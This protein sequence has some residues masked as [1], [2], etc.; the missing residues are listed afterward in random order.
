MAPRPP[1]K[2][3]AVSE[4]LEK[5]LPEQAEEEGGGIDT[6]P[7]EKNFWSIAKTFLGVGKTKKPIR[8]RIWELD[9]LKTFAFLFM[10]LDHLMFMAAFVFYGAWRNSGI[11]WL[12]QFATVARAYRLSEVVDVLRFV[13]CAGVF[14]TVSGI[15]SVLSRNNLRRGTILLVLSLILT[16][17]TYLFSVFAGG[18][19]TIK[20]GIIHLLACCM[21]AGHFCRNLPGQQILAIAV[22]AI[23]LGIFFNQFTVYDEWFLPIFNFRSPVYS[24]ADY[25]PIF[26][27]FGFYMLGMAIGRVCYPKKKSLLP[28]LDG[29]GWLP[30]KWISSKL[31]ILYFAHQPVIVAVLYIIS[32]GRI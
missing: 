20:F 27:N 13:L 19:Y 24:S 31:V 32:G 23:I 9:A 10:L 22:A 3:L 21:I 30:F 26:P 25:Y 8:E 2:R 14:I 15:S 16:L 12:R 11:E 5:T 7:A 28:C 6:Q 17:A 29:R 1:Q 4:F 18:D